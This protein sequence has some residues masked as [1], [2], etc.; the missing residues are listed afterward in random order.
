[1]K[2]FKKN[3]KNL[4]KASVIAANMCR[5]TK[6]TISRD[7]KLVKKT[8]LYRTVQKFLKIFPCEFAYKYSLLCIRKLIYTLLYT[9]SKNPC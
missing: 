5:V 8:R 7:C 6:G 4:M 2:L 1:M 9:K 3:S